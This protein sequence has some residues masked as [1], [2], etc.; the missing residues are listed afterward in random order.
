MLTDAGGLVPALVG[1]RLAQR[2]ATPQRTFGYYRA[3]I[4]AA[5]ANAVLLIGISLYVVYEAYRRLTDPPEGA[6]VP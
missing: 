4:L 2:P 3:E 5:L 1:I 6:T